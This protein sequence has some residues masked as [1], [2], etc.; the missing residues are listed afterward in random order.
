MLYDISN[1][2]SN[3]RPEVK[4]AEGK[5][6]SINN[7]KNGVILMDHAIKEAAKMVE[8]EDKLNAYD[9]V[10]GLM[11]GSEAKEYI[12]T[13]G[14]GLDYY[15]TIFKAITA[16]IQNKT[17]EEIEAEEKNTAPAAFRP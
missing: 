1:K 15:E 2:L 11:L 16:A 17:Y 7:T 3:K 13:Q 14:Y 5:I 10:I 12:A 9:G 6:F 4:L 8:L